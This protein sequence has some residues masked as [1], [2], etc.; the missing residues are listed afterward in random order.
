[1][2]LNNFKNKK[3]FLIIGVV[4][5][6]MILIYLAFVY[7]PGFF[8][9]KSP[10]YLL[11]QRIIRDHGLAVEVKN[12]DNYFV[13][14]P[15]E[16]VRST[17][18]EAE[19]KEEFKILFP[20]FSFPLGEERIDDI[21]FGNLMRSSTLEESFFNRGP[22]SAFLVLDG[23]PRNTVFYSISDATIRTIKIP[24]ESLEFNNSVTVFQ[25]QSGDLKWEIYVAGEILLKEAMIGSDETEKIVSIGTPLFALGNH[26][27]IPASV[28][29]TAGFQIAFIAAKG[30]NYETANL[31]NILTRGGRFVM[32]QSP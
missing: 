19:Q 25:A 8:A 31:L 18:L 13:Y 27:I 5:A 6:A 4:V 10:E 7:G 1:M 24:S 22:G 26:Q 15:V 3:F 32:L 23:F 9:K 17:L 12:W 20:Q 28:F 16:E 14:L 21:S 30:E 2:N 29:G 11:Q